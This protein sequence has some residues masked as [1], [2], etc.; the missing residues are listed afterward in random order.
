MKKRSERLDETVLIDTGCTSVKGCRAASAA[1]TSHSRLPQRASCTG[2]QA[3]SSSAAVGADASTVFESTAQ[4]GS[5]Q[6]GST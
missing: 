3:A 1:P 5:T 4:R 2:A 6:R